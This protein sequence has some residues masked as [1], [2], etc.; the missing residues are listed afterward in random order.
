MSSV[1]EGLPMREEAV[2]GEAEAAGVAEVPA[3]EAA[4]AVELDG[5]C[6]R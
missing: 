5:D 1:R 2:R 6:W 3:A 4:E